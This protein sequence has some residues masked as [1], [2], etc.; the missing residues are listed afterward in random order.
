MEP[1]SGPPVNPLPPSIA[2]ADKHFQS[3]HRILFACIGIGILLIIT[4][5][6]LLA[7]R[8]NTV[9]TAKIV[10]S[11]GKCV[12]NDHNRQMNDNV[13]HL[14][15]CY[16]DANAQAWVL[17]GDTIRLSSGDYCMDTKSSA[18]IPRTPIRLWECNGSDT[19]Q[20]QIHN[21]GT[22]R[23]VKSGLCLE[24]TQ[25]RPVDGNLLWIA[26][27]N[28]NTVAAQKWSVAE[29]PTQASATPGA[30]G[31]NAPSAAHSAAAPP[32]ASAPGSQP[33]SGT[34]SPTSSAPAPA[35]QSAPGPA[36]G[37][38]QGAAPGPSP[39]PAPVPPPPIDSSPNH[40]DCINKPSA[41]G[42]PDATNTGW[43]PTGVK[44]T[45]DGVNI[46]SEGDYVIDQPGTVVDAKEVDGCVIVRA[47]NVTIKRS[48]LTKCKSYFNIRLYPEGSNFTLEDTEVDGNN[49]EGQDNAFVDDGH[50]PVTIRR[51][52]MHNVSDGPHPGEHY[53]L[54]DSY[55][56]DLYAC[57]ICHNDDVQSAGAI[58][59]TLRHNTLVNT[60][61]D[62]PS[63]L[64]GRNAVVRIATEQGPVDGF[65]VDNNLLS[66]GNYAVQD[67][68]Q[69]NGVPQ[70]ITVTNNRIVPN[71]RF[72]PYDFDGAVTLG[73]NYRDDNGA[74]LNTY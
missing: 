70:N 39:A 22:I 20:W 18:V 69:G 12:D 58:D 14:W 13:I 56:T 59:V 36:S 42:Y 71:W 5:A 3:H 31:V 40:H 52:Y 57:S 27:C 1:E 4:I 34:N 19:Q 6:Y 30:A 68:S 10:N 51:M 61:P 25:S 63:G 17:Q 8:P 23:N 53:L 65:V 54:Q 48:L 43:R 21:D 72:G 47:P 64:G 74:G 38:S 73:G 16:K 55:I 46:T 2:P 35:G 60:P 49:A 41:C 15:T 24:D 26:T 32:V 11:A 62:N 29:V 67:R 9:F 50:G 28:P 66:G 7:H 45:T 37:S 44:L 33:N